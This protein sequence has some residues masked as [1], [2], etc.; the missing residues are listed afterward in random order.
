ISAHCIT[1]ANSFNLLF[2][3]ELRGN[4]MGIVRARTHFFS[5]FRLALLAA[6]VFGA[7]SAFASEAELH[8]PELN[9]VFNLF[10]GQVTG[11]ALL[12]S[13][14][15]IAVL[16]MGFGFLEFLRVKKLPAHQSMLDISA[17]IYET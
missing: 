6:A 13:G 4:L 15:V 12:G 3:I 11:T 7:T 14:M 10:G 17:L 2:K 1:S 5:A 8:I 9:T 16:G